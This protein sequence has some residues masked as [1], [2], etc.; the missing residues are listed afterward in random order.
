MGRMVS[1]VLFFKAFTVVVSGLKNLQPST[2][3]RLTSTLIIL[4]FQLIYTYLQEKIQLFLA[5]LLFYRNMYS[6]RC[7][8]AGDTLGYK[9]LY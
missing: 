3:Y 7:L 6:A 8:S 2:R 5:Y 4:N 9:I 1:G